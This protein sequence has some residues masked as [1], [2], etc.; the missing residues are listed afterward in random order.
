M[1]HLINANKLAFLQE[2]DLKPNTN[3]TSTSYDNIGDL[4]MPNMVTLEEASW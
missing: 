4:S 1:H 2:L 3:N